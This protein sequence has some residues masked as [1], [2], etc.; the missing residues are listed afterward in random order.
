MSIWTYSCPVTSTKPKKGQ[1]N[2]RAVRA[3]RLLQDATDPYMTQQQI[4]EASE[5]SAAS[6]ASMFSNRA[7]ITIST[8][9]RLAR[10]MGYTDD[11]AIDALKKVVF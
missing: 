9:L 5:V 2:D 10:G 4:A 6:L 3:L 8:F 1:D 11:Q 7:E